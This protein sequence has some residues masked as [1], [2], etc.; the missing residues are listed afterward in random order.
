MLLKGRRGQVT[1]EM[2]VL[3]GVVVVAL[4]WM[5]GIFGRH[6]KGNVMAQSK[7]VS[8]DPWGTQANYTSKSESNSHTV[9]NKVGM[10]SQS[11]SISNSNLA[12]GAIK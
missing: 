1:M 6:V 2:M 9:S 11:N 10:N 7:T 12:M 8:E 3:W 4:I 5:M